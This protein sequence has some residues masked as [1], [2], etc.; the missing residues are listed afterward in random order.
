MHLACIS[1]MERAIHERVKDEAQKVEVYHMLRVLLI[2]TDIIDIQ[3]KLS[4][5]MTYFEEVNPSFYDY[6]QSTYVTRY[7]K[8][9]PYRGNYDSEQ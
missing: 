3:V 9:S 7:W 8:T 5:A 1:C 6:I 2:E 4:Q